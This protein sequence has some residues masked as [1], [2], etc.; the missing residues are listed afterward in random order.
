M[1]GVVYTS[2][3]VSR[4]MFDPTLTTGISESKDV[5]ELLRRTFDI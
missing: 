4:L 5:D 2:L 1:L 3:L